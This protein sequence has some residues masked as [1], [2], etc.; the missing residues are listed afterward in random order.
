[1]PVNCS[2]IGKTGQL[3]CSGDKINA[4]PLAPKADELQKRLTGQW[5]EANCSAEQ[6]PGEVKALRT[7][8]NGRDECRLHQ[9]P[10]PMPKK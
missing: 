9:D 5:S 8:K 7:G 4:K 2:F 10:P 1:M 6:F 3:V